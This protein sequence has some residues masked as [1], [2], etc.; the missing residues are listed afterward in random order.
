MKIQRTIPP[1]AAHIDLKSVLSGLLG[2]LSPRTE[3]ARLESEFRRYFGVKHVFFVSSGKAALTLI[4]QALSRQAPAKRKVI[5]PAYTCFSV[6][7]AI[8]KAGLEVAPCDIAENTFDFDFMQLSAEI[9]HD[10][11][12][13]VPTHLFGL[14]ADMDRIKA[15]CSGKNVFIVEDAAQAMGGVFGKKQV[16]TIGDAGF[17]SF[18]R[19]KNLTCGSGG[20]IVTDNDAIADSI[21]SLYAG[22]ENSPMRE[23][24]AELIKMVFLTVFINPSL[25]WFPAGLPFLKL[26]ETVFDRDFPV[27]RLSGLKM[28][29]LRK[30]QHRLES[31]NSLRSENVKYYAGGLE[32]RLPENGSLPLI[33]Y[34]FMT[35]SSEERDALS[36]LSQKRGLGVGRMYPTS[37]HEIREIRE[38]FAGRD[39]PGARN[40]AD[41]LVTLPTHGLLT[42][43]DRERILS[44]CRIKGKA[45]IG[46]PASSDRS[47]YA[48]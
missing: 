14:P 16:G 42:Q 8:M 24:V 13:V 46:S 38:R 43:K 12:C 3:R 21:S 29:F 35:D 20:V 28:G 45:M 10:T 30:W 25:Y 41:R 40:A 2:A 32:S 26:G 15:L 22:L 18:G 39:F 5:V 9:D 17:F 23:T 31:S 34:P 4:L 6:P 7:S 47:Q 48:F 27:R 44:Q 37:I 11:L 36:A 1:A 33:R 19:G